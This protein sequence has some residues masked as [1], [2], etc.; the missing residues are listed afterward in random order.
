MSR[1]AGISLLLFGKGWHYL[2]REAPQATPAAFTATRSSAI[3][4]HISYTGRLQILQS[5]RNLIG[6]A[7]DCAL[8]ID[9]NRIAA[10][11]I[12]PAQNRA[13]RRGRQLQLP[14]PV[15]QPAF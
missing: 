4:Q 9:L 2:V 1:A 8:E 15:C 3:Y 14:C 5:P 11:A 10:R 6:R 12:G 7:I 13:V